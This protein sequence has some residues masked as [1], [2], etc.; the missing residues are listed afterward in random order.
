MTEKKKKLFIIICIGKKMGG[1][2]S[3]AMKETKKNKDNVG[4][5]MGHNDFFF[6]TRS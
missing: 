6:R 1:K 5:I 3:N 4:S 2:E